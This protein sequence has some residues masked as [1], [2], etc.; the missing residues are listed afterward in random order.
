MTLQEGYRQILLF[1]RTRHLRNSIAWPCRKAIDSFCYFTGL[2][3]WGIVSYDLAGRFSRVFCYF[4]G[5]VTW[6]IISYDLAGRLSTVFC[7][8]TGHVTWGIVSYDLA[9]RLSTVFCYFTGHVAWG[10]V[11][12][13]LAGRLSTIFLCSEIY[14]TILNRL[15]LSSQFK[16]SLRIS[17]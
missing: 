9:G 16:K 3:A 4:T 11:L 12:Y 10:I 1:H 2:V 14:I 15:M 8:F 7:Y 6:G 13:D 17:T 5:H